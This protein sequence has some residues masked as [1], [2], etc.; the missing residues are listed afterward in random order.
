MSKVRQST[1]SKIEEGVIELKYEASK[2]VAAYPNPKPP[3]LINA[4]SP[5]PLRRESASRKVN[6]NFRIT[7]LINKTQLYFDAKYSRT[8]TYQMRVAFM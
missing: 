3:S 2:F 6:V 8:I 4:I 5:D 1:G 7:S